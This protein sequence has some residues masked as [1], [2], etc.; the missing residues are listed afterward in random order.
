LCLSTELVKD[1]VRKKCEEF[2]FGDKNSNMKKTPQHAD[3]RHH[4]ISNMKTPHNLSRVQTGIP[5]FD[6]RI[7]IYIPKNR[8]LSRS[9][10]R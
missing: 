8:E 2:V 4:N 3:A 5:S 10:L 6:F 9:L 1:G 7:S